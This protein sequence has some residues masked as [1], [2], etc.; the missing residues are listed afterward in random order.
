[1]VEQ[2]RVKMITHMSVSTEFSLPFHLTYIMCTALQIEWCK[3]R[4]WAM[5]W[6]EEVHLLIE[7]MG[8]VVQ[9]L[10]WKGR[11]WELCADFLQHNIVTAEDTTVDLLGDH[12]LQAPRI[13]G[14]KAYGLRQASV[15]R[16]LHDH[17]KSLWHSVPA[18]VQLHVCR[19]GR[20]VVDIDSNTL[21]EVAAAASFLLD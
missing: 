21:K 5:Q 8:Q 19:D 17:F 15:Q 13:E 7:E 4:A 20:T 1:M 10:Q 3:A 18:L 9:F 12:H 11:F 16:G 14:T 6:S 2:Q